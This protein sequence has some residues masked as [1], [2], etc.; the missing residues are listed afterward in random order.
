MELWHAALARDVLLM[1]NAL[2]A[3]STPM[4]EPVLDD[5]IDR[6]VD[7]ARVVHR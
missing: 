3:I 6:L 1:P 2:A 5:A 7:A 4:T